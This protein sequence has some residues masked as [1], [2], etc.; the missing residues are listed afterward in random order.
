MKY[1]SKKFLS[2]GAYESGSVCIYV[3][4]PR[5]GKEFRS[6][7]TVDAQ[8]KIG[9]CSK[10]AELDFSLSKDGD[11]EK[12]LNK[13]DVLIDELT[14]MKQHLQDQWKYVK[15]NRPEKDDD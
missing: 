8:V 2:D 12:R 1:V 4:S 3:T 5:E 9:D 15:E 11:L 6:Y 10:F 14:N 13:L 7:T